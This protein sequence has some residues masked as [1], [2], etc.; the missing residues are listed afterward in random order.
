VILVAQYQVLFKQE[1]KMQ[2]HDITPCW[3]QCKT[4]KPHT[5]T[6][7]TIVNALSASH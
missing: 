6:M 5:A 3:Q 2:T 4:T 7:S 1:C